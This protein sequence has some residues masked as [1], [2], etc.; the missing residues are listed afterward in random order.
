MTPSL[1]SHW[2]LWCKH[3]YGTCPLTAL[4][5]HM[6]QLPCLWLHLRWAR[7]SGQPLNR[8]GTAYEL[9]P[10]NW[11]SVQV[12]RAMLEACR[13]SSCDVP[14][15]VTFGQQTEEWKLVPESS[16]CVLR[17]LWSL[18]GTMASWVILVPGDL[19]FAWNHLWS[20]PCIATLSP[21]MMEC[22]SP[23]LETTC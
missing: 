22:V 13:R 16:R 9:L 11:L 15:E 4:G 21:E 23:S 20:L 7:D 14:I 1:W 10:G 2:Q 5:G 8:L 19:G 12:Q 18:M 17:K 6:T 3:V